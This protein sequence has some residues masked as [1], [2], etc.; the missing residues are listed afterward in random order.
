MIIEYNAVLVCFGKILYEVCKDM[1]SFYF[2]KFNC[3]MHSL[4]YVS[5]GL[6]GNLKVALKGPEPLKSQV[7]LSS[8]D[9]HTY[10]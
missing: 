6:N 9:T 7:F 2:A 10:V 5:L 1:R 8:L 4:T 3:N